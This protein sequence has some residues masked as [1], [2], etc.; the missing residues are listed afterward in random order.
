M[1]LS[2]AGKVY[3]PMSLW[4]LVYA[5]WS[6]YEP[7]IWWL[8]LSG[9]STINGGEEGGKQCPAA[10]KNS[11]F[12]HGCLVHCFNSQLFHFVGISISAKLLEV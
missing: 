11:Q 5:S 12:A 7:C 4:L 1:G 3:V 10:F 6:I 8:E 9:S 2:L